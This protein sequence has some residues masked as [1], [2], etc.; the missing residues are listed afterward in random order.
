[1]IDEELEVRQMF[2]EEAQEYINTMD[3]GLI[4]I[5][6][7]PNFKQQIDAIL[8]AAHSLK[9]AAGIMQFDALSHTAHRLEDAF[10]II[11]SNRPTIDVT[12][13]RLLLNAVDLL[14]R[15]IVINR[16]GKEVNVNWLEEHNISIFEP[17]ETYLHNASATIQTQ[18]SDEDSDIAILMFESEVEAMLKN[19]E[20]K[21]AT[22]QINFYLIQDLTTI[23]NDL[24]D[25][26]EMLELPNFVQLCQEIAQ[27]IE[28]HPQKIGQI[29]FAAIDAWRRSQALI[30]L[31]NREDIPSSIDFD[32]DAILESEEMTV[33]ESYDPQFKSQVEVILPEPNITE[34][35]ESLIDL[36]DQ[37]DQFISVDPEPNSEEI[38][39]LIN[40]NL[41]NEF[42]EYEPNPFAAPT[43]IDQPLGYIYDYSSPFDLDDLPNLE[44]SEIGVIRETE[45]ESLDLFGDL[46]EDENPFQSIPLIDDIDN[47]LGDRFESYDLISEI[48]PPE[49]FKIEDWAVDC[50]PNEQAS[51]FPDHEIDQDQLADLTIDQLFLEVNSNPETS[52]FLDQDFW[53]DLDGMVGDDL[54]SNNFV[55]FKTDKNIEKNLDDLSLDGINSSGDDFWIGLDNIVESFSFEDSEPMPDLTSELLTPNSDLITNLE[56]IDISQYLKQSTSPAESSTEISDENIL[57][58]AMADTLD[59]LQEDLEDSKESDI[60]ESMPP[61]ALD[62]VTTYVKDSSIRLPISRLDQLHSLSG[63]LLVGHNSL[64]VQ[65]KRLRELL[66]SLDHR[67][68]G[69]DDSNNQL[70]VIYDRMTTEL[71]LKPVSLKPLVN[72]QA[73]DTLEMDSYSELHSLSQ[74]VS[75]AIVQLQE[76]VEDVD[77]TLTEAEQNT[78]NLTSNFR[79]L[80]TAIKQTRMRPLADIV[81][82]FPRVVRGLALQHNKNVEVIIT[83]AEI[84]L[85]QSILDILS[86]PLNHL[87]RNAFDHGIEDKTMRRQT[88]KKEQGKI[89]INITQ[90]EDKVLIAIS[91]DGK[92]IDVEQIRAKAL[93]SPDLKDID[94]LA[95]MTAS[96]L[97][98][99]IFEPGFSTLEKVTTLSGRGIGMDVVR[100]NLQQIGAE[101]NVDTRVGIG[102]TF[103]IAVPFTRSSLRIVLIEVDQMLFGIPTNLIQEVV[104]LT[105][106][107]QEDRYPWQDLLIPVLNLSDRLQI[108][109]PHSDRYLE[110]KPLSAA[111][112]MVVINKDG[113]L[114]AIPVNGCWA[115]QEVTVLQPQGQ[116]SLPKVFSGCAIAANGQAIP[117]LDFTLL[118]DYKLP[119]HQV[120]RS[121]PATAI[122]VVD[123]SVN[124]RRYLALIFKKAGFKVEQAKDGEE[125]IDK[126]LNGLIVNAVISDVEMPRLDGYGLLTRI[127]KEPQFKKLPVIML[128]SRSGQ[129][130]RQL[131]INL[132]A[133]DYFSKPFEEEK[134]IQTIRQ[135]VA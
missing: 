8:R 57:A 36:F 39:E 52:D 100:T 51:T 79:Q 109:C 6:Q 26:G 78:T 47:S 101:I 21:L 55:D 13:E 95:I 11:K 7:A 19:L 4:G 14:R 135:L 30:I 70:A 34:E 15:I 96:R 35:S 88:G 54:D 94:Q 113:E 62:L 99:L 130:H 74:G 118:A 5:D 46:F 24:S 68:R 124:V 41:F 81:G 104:P 44:I 3:D 123:D 102:T 126:L 117:L 67:V 40:L 72:A 86:D 83:G 76:V 80:Q 107:Y 108:N 98:Q 85:E 59:D 73:F 119:P 69:L 45:P 128:T 1:M 16:Q 92:G 75:E 27:N 133:T 28:A 60:P 105:S 20:E 63:E 110:D 43:T 58:F 37:F 125:A 116:L 87:L 38:P 71:G 31:G 77:L 129:K 121:Q 49:I 18:D 120:L 115:E 56:K 12:T 64:D 61:S 66:K 2:L 22:D 29:A 42:E 89:E 132:G 114:M 127:R 103:T 106:D 131:A 82:R 9:G 111:K 91:D 134:L 65:L 10:K 122:L 97:M 25:L 23:A 33:L 84:L 17:L 48:D 32:P 90:K 112:S 93:R 53:S 50:D